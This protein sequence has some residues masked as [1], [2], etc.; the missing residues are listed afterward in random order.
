VEGYG[1]GFNSL[2][3][4]SCA[5]QTGKWYYE[6]ELSSGGIMQVSAARNFNYYNR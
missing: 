1:D 6:V 4:G 5:L 3:V 2:A